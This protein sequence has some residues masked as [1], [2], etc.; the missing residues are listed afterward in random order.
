[1]VWYI[2]GGAVLLVALVVIAAYLSWTAT[3]VD[4]L[5]TRAEAT[6]SALDAQTYHR[7]AMALEVAHAGILDPAA[8]LFLLDAAHYAQ[9]ASEAE[10]ESAESNLTEAL[11]VTFD[12]PAEAARVRQDHE[13]GELVDELASACRRVEMARRIHNDTVT[14]ASALRR[15]RVVRTF[16]LAGHAI[17]P[18]TVELQDAPPPGLRP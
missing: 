10:R 1:M 5:H 3:R 7:S 16:H 15:R 2:V 14:M 18:A 17:E 4:R 13:A 12:D 9:A 11:A 8:S 6:R